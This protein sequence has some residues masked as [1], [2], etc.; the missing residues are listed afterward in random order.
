MNKNALVGGALVGTALSLTD[1]NPWHDRVV[2]ATITGGAIAIAAK[3]LG[4]LS[5]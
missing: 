3:F 5:H 2:Q 4:N 1:S